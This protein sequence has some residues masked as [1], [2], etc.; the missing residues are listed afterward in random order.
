MTENHSAPPTGATS[1]PEIPVAFELTG[2][3]GVFSSGASPFD[4]S[5]EYLL[6]MSTGNL[7]IFIRSG[8]NK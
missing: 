6:M 1:Y 7:S 8:A 2:V 5:S 3:S 4:F